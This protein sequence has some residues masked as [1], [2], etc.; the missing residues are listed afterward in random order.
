[1][2]DEVLKIFLEY[3]I[4]NNWKSYY[5]LPVFIELL[6]KH[7]ALIAF[8]P[9]LRSILIQGFNHQS[10]AVKKCSLYIL[11]TK[12]PNFQTDPVWIQ[13]STYFNSLNQTNKPIL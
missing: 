12:I 7:T 5:N 11:S 2:N 4:Q 10:H 6:S 3:L 1:M 13:F 9:A 8:T